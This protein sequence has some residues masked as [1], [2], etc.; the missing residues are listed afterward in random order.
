MRAED[1]LISARY[2]HDLIPANEA[3]QIHMIAQGK[4]GPPAL[5]AMALEPGLFK[6][7]TLRKSLVSW[8]NVVRTPVTRD[9]LTNTVHGALKIY[10]LPDLVK[11]I[12]SKRIKVQEPVNAQNKIVR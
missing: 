2:L 4:A 1:I 12:G 9:V 3:K 7:L 6:S 5:H 8:S 10:D 11:L